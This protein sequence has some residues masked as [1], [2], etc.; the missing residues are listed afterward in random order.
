MSPKD[1]GIMKLFLILYSSN[2]TFFLTSGMA[3]KVPVTPRIW[4][5]KFGNSAYENLATT[6]SIPRTLSRFVFDTLFCSYSKILAK[7]V[8]YP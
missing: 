7:I 3:L 4:E 8:E 1:E 6:S 2:S 5:K